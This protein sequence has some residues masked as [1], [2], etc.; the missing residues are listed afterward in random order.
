M[1][2]FILPGVA[3]ENPPAE[4]L[5]VHQRVEVLQSAS[6]L[7]GPSFWQDQDKGQTLVLLQDRVGY[8][9]TLIEKFRSTLSQVYK[10]LFP[11]NPPVETLGKLW[12]KFATAKRVT[13]LVREQTIGGARLALA[14]SLAHYPNMDLQLIGRAYAAI[15]EA[16]DNLMDDHM[17]AAIGPAESLVTAVLRRSDIVTRLQAQGQ[18]HGLI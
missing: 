1:R 4:K 16:Q 2:H 11:L 9:E 6:S 10:T 5:R 13:A 18:G 14:F 7:A 3:V 12:E 15:S 17:D 8:V